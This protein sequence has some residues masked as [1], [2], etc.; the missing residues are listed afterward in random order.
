MLVTAFL[1]SQMVEQLMSKLVRLPSTRVNGLLRRA[2][3]ML[4]MDGTNGFLLPKALESNPAIAVKVATF[5]TAGLNY[6]LELFSDNAE[7]NKELFEEIFEWKNKSSIKGAIILSR[8]TSGDCVVDKKAAFRN[9]QKMCRFLGSLSEA[10]E[11]TVCAVTDFHD[12]DSIADN[13]TAKLVMHLHEFFF[14][15]I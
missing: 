3:K 5:S 12:R 9:A 10:Q 11:M 15:K 1:E 4:Q 2:V 13:R 6:Y 8:Q 7:A 14:R